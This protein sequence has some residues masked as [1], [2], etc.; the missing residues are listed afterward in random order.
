L[1]IKRWIKSIRV[2]RKSREDKNNR[3]GCKS[4]R[5]FKIM[6]LCGKRKGV[7]A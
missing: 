3:V 1:E 5:K 7:P 6:E 4:N 2:G